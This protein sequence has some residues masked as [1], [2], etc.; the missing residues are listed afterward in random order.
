MQGSWVRFQGNALSN[1]MNTLNKM[2]ATLI[3]CKSISVNERSKHTWCQQSVRLF[4]GHVVNMSVCSSMNDAC[5]VQERLPQVSSAP[6][7]GGGYSAQDH[8]DLSQSL[9][10]WRH[11][12][13]ET[14]LHMLMTHHTYACDSLIDCFMNNFE[15]LSFC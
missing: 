8:A 7:G 11:W 10:P 4:S 13:G 3:K 9:L 2:Q 6:C 1:K 12:W 15:Y 5:Y 14:D